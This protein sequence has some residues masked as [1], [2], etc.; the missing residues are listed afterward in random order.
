MIRTQKFNWEILFRRYPQRWL[1]VYENDKKCI[2]N[3]IEVHDTQTGE[4]WC[5]LDNNRWMAM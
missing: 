4:V 3:L 5:R 2:D 1:P